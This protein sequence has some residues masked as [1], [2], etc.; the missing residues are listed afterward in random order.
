MAKIKVRVQ[1]LLGGSAKK[2]SK[3]VGG[4]QLSGGM[5]QISDMIKGAA[6]NPANY[7]QKAKPSNFM[8]ESVKK[9]G[10]FESAGA[11]GGAAV[12]RGVAKIGSYANRA[13]GL[14]M[15]VAGT[16]RSKVNNAVKVVKKKERSAAYQ[17]GKLVTGSS[18]NQNVNRRVG[19]ISAGLG[20]G[21]AVGVGAVGAHIV[22]RSREGSPV[23]SSM[24]NETSQSY[25]SS[26]WSAHK[27]TQRGY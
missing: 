2:I 21:S 7:M 20:A 22:N 9:A 16:A 3:A 1:G 17:V 4:K 11:R 27:K 13:K 26:A 8:N 25:N 14:A 18:K 15:D 5:K 19:R 24:G 23:K 12:D 10:R 6:R